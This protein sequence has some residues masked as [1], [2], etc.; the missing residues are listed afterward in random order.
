MFWGHYSLS[1]IC[2]SCQS[3]IK[4]TIS[5]QKLERSHTRRLRIASSATLLS[6]LIAVSSMCA[7]QVFSR[8]IGKEEAMKP[9]ETQSTMGPVDESEHPYTGRA[10]DEGQF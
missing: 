4:Y 10:Q 6:Q 9:G 2:F 5:W 8:A 1:Y 3:K 7:L